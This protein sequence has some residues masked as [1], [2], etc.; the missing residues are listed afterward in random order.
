M[1]FLFPSSSFYL[2]LVFAIFLLFLWRKEPK[3]LLYLLIG[4]ALGLLTAFFR[5]PKLTSA[6]QEFVGVVIERKE[7]YFLFLSKGRRFYLYDKNHS[8]EV[9]DILNIS[10]T[11]SSYVFASYES[12]FDFA[13]YLSSRG[14]EEEID[15]SKVSFIFK[16]PLRMNYFK[17][18]FLANF[19]SE[20]SPLLSSLLFDQKDYSS[21]SISEASS[22][23]ALYFLSSSGLYYSLLLR[24]IEKGLSHFLNE[25]KSKILTLIIGFFALLITPTKIGVWRVYLSYL[26]ILILE[27]KEKDYNNLLPS[28]LSGWTLILVDPLSP[29]RSGFL[30]GEGLSFFT[31]FSRLYLSSKE[32]IKKKVLSKLLF[33]AFILPIHLENG[34]FHL[35]MPLYGTILTLP[36]FLF[37]AIGLVSFLSFPFPLLLNPLSWFIS[38]LIA[39]FYK[40]D[41]VI[42]IG[43]NISNLLI[44]IYYFCLCLTMYFLE[45]GFPK[46]GKYSMGFCALIFALNA[47]PFGQGVSSSVSFINVGQGDG[48]L[49][50]DGYSYVMIDTGGNI[51][52]DL[53]KE[54]DLPFLHKE[55]IYHLDALIASHGDYDHI[56]AASS[57]S[58]LI[59]IR[60][61]IDDASSFPLKVGR[62]VFTNYNHFSGEEEN[63]KS[64]V[65]SLTLGQ[66][67][68]LFTGDAPISIE[69]QI[70]KEHPN[71]PCDILKLGHHG[72]LTS[73]CEEFLKALSPEVAIISVGAKNHYGHPSEVVLSRLTSLSIPYRRTDK[74]G[75]ITYFSF[76]GGKMRDK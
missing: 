20:T 34:L 12:R 22:L 62:M 13:N 16:F 54:V 35:L 41:L 64:L 42:P 48:I 58:T 2:V 75:T 44:F 18:K 67:V 6:K 10:G 8:Y 33:F 36:V 63:E 30:L 31:I 9:G 19:N 17:E 69:K 60:N 59:P 45:T 26:Y 57:L 73:S 3:V 24:G 65:L 40:I 27:R 71:I 5:F 51:T 46:F 43:G 25:R 47:M 14:V 4:I 38:W 55:R 74:E 7:N 15:I 76:C 68:F 21:L 1:A 37:V 72:S 50:R 56:G 49:I 23:G 32:G 52:F 39:L 61:Y 28:S 70:V 53:A 29:L 66:K 11:N